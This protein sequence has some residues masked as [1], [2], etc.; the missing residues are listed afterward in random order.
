MSNELY[1]PTYAIPLNTQ[2][3]KQQIRLGL[4]GFP[5]V[6]KTFA[7][8]TFPNPVVLDFDR[9]LGA[10]QGRAD[11]IAIPFYD[12]A[13]IDSIVPRGAEWYIPYGK[14]ASEK[15]K[16]PANRKD[17]LLKWLYEEASKFSIEQTLIVDGN[18]T[19]QAAYHSQYWTAPELDRD[20]KVKP[21]AEFRQKIDY[22]TEVFTCLKALKCNVVYIAHESDAR[23][24]KG[25]LNGKIRPLMSGAI[26]DEI[27]S[28][29][30]DWFRC[31]A[32]GK[33]KTEVEWTNAQKF[34][35]VDRSVIQEWC[36]FSDNDTMYLWQTTSDADVDCGSSSLI[37]APK[38]IPA[39]FSMFEKYRKKIS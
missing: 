13:F 17:A 1:I 37:G 19:I 26:K 35:G 3:K 22:F 29:F 34:F 4:Q 12:D 36:K 7:A 32:Y 33:P 8:L 6:G 5:K 31:Y 27:L 18:T 20:S 10:H 15:K 28:H 16:R 30:T 2:T 21:Y 24:D 25:H 11:V 23:D 38:W 9:G 14:L 39:H